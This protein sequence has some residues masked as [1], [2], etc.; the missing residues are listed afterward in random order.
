MDKAVVISTLKGTL[1]GLARNEVLKSATTELNPEN[2]LG[3]RSQTQSIRSWDPATG[4]STD[5]RRWLPGSG[6]CRRSGVLIDQ[7][8]SLG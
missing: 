1:S 7:S 3:E 8:F 5:W 4:K 2:L 6:G